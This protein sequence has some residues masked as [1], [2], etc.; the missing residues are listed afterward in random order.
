M[1]RHKLAFVLPAAHLLIAFVLIAREDL[2]YSQFE[3]ESI[4][5]QDRIERVEKFRPEL[6]P[7][8][9]MPREQ[10]VGWS[11]AMEYRPSAAVKAMMGV[12]FPATALIGWYWH[13]P[14][15]FSYAPLQPVLRKL[16]REIPVM[17]R[18]LILDFL[19]LAGVGGQW[20]VVGLWLDYRKM[21]DKSI[22]LQR[23]CMTLTWAGVTAAV[24]CWPSGPSEIVANLAALV[25][26]LAWLILLGA[27]VIAITSSIARLFRRATPSTA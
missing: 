22:G 9:T 13:P 4:K 5:R 12:E 26:L 27:A 19:L 16:T 10:E 11:I 7:P 17:P 23:L 15:G 25:A 14:S 21:R 2:R 3:I 18:I 1:T 24:F 20:W 6:E 8:P